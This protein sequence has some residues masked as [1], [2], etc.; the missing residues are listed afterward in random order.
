[1]A[2][3]RTR[4][5][6]LRSLG[7]P[8]NARPLGVPIRGSALVIILVVTTLG[9]TN[10]PLVAS[11]ITVSDPNK[12]ES[13]EQL[14]RRSDAVA[15]VWMT[16]AIPEGVVPWLIV[17]A[18]VGWAFKGVLNDELV[19]FRC[20]KG[21][22]VGERY[23]VF[24]SRVGKR[25]GELESAQRR[26]VILPFPKDAEYFRPT[27]GEGDPFPVIYEPALGRKNVVVALQRIEELPT[28]VAHGPLPCPVQRRLAWWADYD[29][30]KSY[31]IDLA[32][33]RSRQHP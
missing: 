13:V 29:E 18:R 30:L 9:A 20:W 24:L 21:C 33:S 8:L 31:L 15:V 1:M 14:F 32:S 4:R 23:L 22:L 5:L 7:S 2:L 17:Q 3:Q 11:D 12:I 25:L 10:F 6:S 27:A 28:Q 19:Y 16:A 26:E